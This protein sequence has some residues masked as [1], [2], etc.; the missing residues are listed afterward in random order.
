MYD[1]YI[2]I[3]IATQQWIPWSHTRNQTAAELTQDS[4]PRVFKTKGGA[5]NY[6]NWWLEGVN[7]NEWIGS[8]FDGNAYID[9]G[10]RQCPERKLC[11]LTVVPVSI[12][13]RI[14]LSARPRTRRNR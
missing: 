8:T 10:L 11:E 13:E 5:K 2:I 7:Y 9:Y 4:P 6:I 1:G 12:I 3:D 14:E